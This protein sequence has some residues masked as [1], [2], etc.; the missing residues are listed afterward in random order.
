M[1][2]E[3]I[4]AI[5]GRVIIGPVVK[6]SLIRSTSC[7]FKLYRA[8][9][10]CRPGTLRRRG[11]AELISLGDFQRIV[12]QWTKTAKTP[13]FPPVLCPNDLPD[14]GARQ[15]LAQVRVLRRALPM[16][17]APALRARRKR[18]LSGVVPCPLAPS[19]LPVPPMFSY[20]PPSGPELSLQR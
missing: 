9:S 15:L 2:I 16:D 18:S 4:G 1:S 13:S 3:E 8:G 11:R 17:D 6:R 20:R 5:S 7:S 12:R 19:N 10:S 14:A